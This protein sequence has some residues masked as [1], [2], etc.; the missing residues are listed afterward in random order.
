MRRSTHSRLRT[1]GIGQHPSEHVAAQLLLPPNAAARRGTDD[2]GGRS[3]AGRIR[4]A[5]SPNCSRLTRRR[6]SARCCKS[7]ATSTKSGAGFRWVRCRIGIDVGSANYRSCAHWTYWVAGR[8][9]RQDFRTDAAGGVAP[10]CGQAEFRAEPLHSGWLTKD[11]KQSW[12]GRALWH[13]PWSEELR[14]CRR[15]SGGQRAAAM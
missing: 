12:R 3:A 8:R 7:S 1:P 2:G 13:C 10:L 5:T 9:A 14:L 11:R 4:G 15:D 6:Q